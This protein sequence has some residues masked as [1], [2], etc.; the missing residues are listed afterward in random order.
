VKMKSLLA[1]LSVIAVLF[2][3]SVGF[4]Q[5]E[6]ADESKRPVKETRNRNELAQAPEKYRSRPNP[7]ASDH[8]AVAAGGILF[9]QHCS[10]CHG[11]DAGGSRRGPSLLRDRV[12]EAPP[13]A[14][15]WL[16]TN[17]V[18]RHG[19]PVWSKLPEPQ[20]WQI[21]SYIKS[22]GAPAAKP[23]GSAAAKFQPQ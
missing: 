18:V 1:V 8:N 11:K 16:V 3:A 2:G 13:G 7:M 17:G 12:Q 9:E 14:V 19:M 21:V 10:E 23:S 22:L 6:K 5:H 15:F 20:R 4:A